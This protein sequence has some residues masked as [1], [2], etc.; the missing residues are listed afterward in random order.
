LDE[1]TSVEYGWTYNLTPY[2]MAKTIL[3]NIEDKYKKGK[4]IV[5]E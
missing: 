4:N 1:S 5:L 3:T 2:D